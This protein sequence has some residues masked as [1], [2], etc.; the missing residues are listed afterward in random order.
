MQIID[1][2]DPARI[3]TGA[4]VSSKKRALEMLSELLADSNDALGQSEVFSA[5]LS[6]EKLGSTGLGHGVALPHGRLGTCGHPV[7]A[8]AV[9][10]EPIDF[11]AIDGQPVDI[12]FAMLVPEA[13]TDEHLQ[14][15]AQLAELF[16]DPGTCQH[17]RSSDPGGLYDLLTAWRPSQA[18]A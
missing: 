12:L 7:G 6:R 1:I 16:G 9:L 17:L 15:L 4:T 8:L 2:I 14:L 13:S 5:L 10:A 3:V 18:T 11:D